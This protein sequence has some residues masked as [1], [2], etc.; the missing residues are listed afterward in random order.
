MSENNRPSADAPVQRTA[1]RNT[2]K[3]GSQKNVRNPVSVQNRDHRPPAG[4]NPGQDPGQ[5]PAMP[6]VRRGY[7]YI[8]RRIIV[9]NTSVICLMIMLP[10]FVLLTLFLT[11]FPRSTVS[12]VENRNLNTWPSFSFESFFSGAYTAGIA[13]WYNDTVPFRDDMNAAGNN[14]KKLFGIHTDEE[15]T[16][17]GPMREVGKGSTPA[18]SSSSGK[19]QPGAS[20]SPSGTQTPAGQTPDAQTPEV[21]SI[22]EAEYTQVENGTIVVKHNGHYRALELFGGGT[23]NAYVEALNRFHQD[24]GDKVQI[25]SM[26]APLAS[27]Y[28]TPTNYSG[29]SASQKECFDSIASRLDD[30]IK[31]VDVATALSYHTPEEIYFRTDHHWA[32]LGAYYACQELAK[33]AGLDF[34]DLSTYQKHDIEGFVGTMYAVTGDANINND[35]ETFSY[36]TPENVDQCTAYYYTTDFTYDGFGRF[37]QGVGDPQHN[38]YL[39]YMGGDE[40]VVKVKTNVKNGRKALIVKDSYGNSVPGFLFGSFEEIYVVD[41]RYFDLNLVDFVQQTG[42]TD[43]IFAMVSYS[44]VGINS[45]NLETL[46]TQ[47]KGQPIVDGALTASEEE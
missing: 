33:T 5:P 7:N 4:H 46:R 3:A 17:T 32:A 21:S 6:P 9:H 38:A 28:Y 37:F 34:K 19:Q 30:S 23:G 35:P 29:Y 15:V 18:P 8:K 20:T 40:K 24:L 16:A 36:Y 47:A 12:Y 2:P 45:T 31:T 14:F 10:V 39:T 1:S 43:L 25:Y 41:M 22:G 13:D 44:A 11:F 27:E 42:T 26:I